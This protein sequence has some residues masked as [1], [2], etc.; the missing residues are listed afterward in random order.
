MKI[1]KQQALNSAIS[2]EV[3]KGNV[4]ESKI[5]EQNDENSEEDDDY[6]GGEIFEPDI[7][8]KNDSLDIFNFNNIFGGYDD[9]DEDDDELIENFVL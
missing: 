2:Q 9:D 1:I 5:Y 3:E 4:Q 8:S 6:D 7:K